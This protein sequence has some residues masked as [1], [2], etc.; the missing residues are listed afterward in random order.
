MSTADLQARL[1]QLLAEFSDRLLQTFADSFTAYAAGAAVAPA[2][3]APRAAARKAAPAKGKATAKA[4]AK[5]VAKPA[6]KAAKAAKASKPR[7]GRKARGSAADGRRLP[8]ETAAVAQRFAD[9]VTANPGKKIR[10]IGAAL[11]MATDDLALPVAKALKLGLVRKEGQRSATAYF[12][13]GPTGGDSSRKG[14][15]KR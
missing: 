10:E 11:A 15:K 6:A 1:N 9:F 14:R 4:A 13:A 7:P 5:P 8:A 12:P 2:P 3:A